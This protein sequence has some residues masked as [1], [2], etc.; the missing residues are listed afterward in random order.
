MR[1][2]IYY[3]RYYKGSLTDE[4]AL[5][6]TSNMSVFNEINFGRIREINKYVWGTETCQTLY[7]HHI[8]GGWEGRQ[9]TMIGLSLLFLLLAELTSFFS[10][11]CFIQL[12]VF[13][14]L[15]LT[16]YVV[17]GVRHMLRMC[18][19]WCAVCIACYGCGTESVSHVTG[20]DNMWLEILFPDL[21]S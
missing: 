12:T 18:V 21:F 11:R 4:S 19:P 2:W 13:M 16:V 6:M 3:E 7:K 15:N 17:C 5:T 9:L 20:E 14:P 1:G 10:L 8:N